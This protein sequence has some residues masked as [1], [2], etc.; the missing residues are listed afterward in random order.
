M[1]SSDFSLRSTPRHR[2]SAGWTKTETGLAAAGVSPTMSGSACRMRA[3]DVTGRSSRAEWLRHGIP[4]P[5]FR[6]KSVPPVGIELLV[7]SNPEALGRNPDRIAMKPYQRM[8]VGAD[9]E[10]GHGPGD[11]A[12]VPRSTPM[13]AK[14][15]AA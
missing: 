6:G 11:R 8:P 3:I 12:P 14:I 4:V 1:R 2:A 5:N 7:R 13:S 9:R 15:V 10:A